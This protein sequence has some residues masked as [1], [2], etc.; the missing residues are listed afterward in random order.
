MWDSETFRLLIPALVV[1]VGWIVG[2][3]FNVERDRVSKRHDLRI[4]YLID[5]Y[6]R[7]ESAAL[8]PEQDFEHKLNFESAIADIQLLG[9]QSQIKELFSFLEA[10]KKNDGSALID[11]LLEALRNELRT[12]LGLNDAPHKIIVFRFTPSGK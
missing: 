8:R 10:Y 5:A 9:D 7:L 11:P 12:E 3:K 2:H 4:K 6:R 1:V